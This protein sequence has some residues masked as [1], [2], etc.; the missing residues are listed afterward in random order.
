[1]IKDSR[2]IEYYNIEVIVALHKLPSNESS[3][4]TVSINKKSSTNSY[5]LLPHDCHRK[6]QR[7]RTLRAAERRS[8]NTMCSFSTFITGMHYNAIIHKSTLEI[9]RGSIIKIG[10]Y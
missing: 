1:M 5:K 6:E 2:F 3:V 9:T 8:R 7:R 10:G 4:Q